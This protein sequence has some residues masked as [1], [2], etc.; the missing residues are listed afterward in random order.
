MDSQ[1]QGF[2]E[3]ENGSREWRQG[4]GVCQEVDLNEAGFSTQTRSLTGC[5][6]RTQ[7]WTPGIPHSTLNTPC[8]LA[9]G[10]SIGVYRVSGN[11]P[12]G[13]A[14]RAGRGRDEGGGQ[15]HKSR[16]TTHGINLKM[17]FRSGGASDFGVMNTSPHLQSKLPLTQA[18]SCSRTDC[19]LSHMNTS[20][21]AQLKS[22]LFSGAFPDHP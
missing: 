12:V 2:C 1:N 9:P 18:N 17:P 19:P 11:P 15:G 3:K 16:I 14:G 10:A 13:R 4:D 6:K 21:Q 22:V 7:P 8:V 20:V 5:G